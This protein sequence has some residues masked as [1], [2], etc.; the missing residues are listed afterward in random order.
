LGKIKLFKASSFYDLYLEYFK[1]NNNIDLSKSYSDLESQ[2]FY[3]G[4][5]W[6]D[7][8]KYYLEQ[9]DSF[10]VRDVIVNCSWIQN[11]W[12]EE[13][14][15]NKSNKTFLDILELQILD[16]QP[17]VFFAHDM[18]IITSEF[19]K[20]IKKK[21]PSI[22]KVIGYDGVGH[23][24]IS[25]FSKF[26]LVLTCVD[27]IREFYTNYGIRSELFYYGFD[28]RIINRLGQK[29]K[30]LNLS[31]IGGL[32]LMK[33]GHH[34]RLKVLSAL[35]KI[36]PSYFI[37]SR[38]LCGYK[39]YQWQQRK[40]LFD[41]KFREMINVNRVGS[42][43]IGERYGLEMFRE[44]RDSKLTLN[45]HIDNAKNSAANIRLFEATGVGTCLVTDWKQNL[46][47]F[48]NL[49]NEIVTFKS[50]EECIEKVVYL[51]N[52]PKKREEIALAG[53]KKTNQ[54]YGMNNRVKE[55]ENIF[56]KSL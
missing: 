39:F 21:C 11:K 42:C 17:H 54:L 56:L 31:F 41:F 53:Q 40:R 46:S 18:G 8:L 10:E 50:T 45:V 22:K 44:L 19:I 49:D 35:S 27:Y 37:S 13:R 20:K 28:L 48:F 26:D 6:S 14:G 38:E 7:S 30:P 12:L 24:N 47:D 1:N 51:L 16:F 34:Y 2:L 4:F 52:N 9:N 3:D 15:D 43:N 23:L 32:N 29:D 5:A 25:H 33:G 36:K 55:L